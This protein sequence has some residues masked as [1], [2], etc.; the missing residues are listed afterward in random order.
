MSF[1]EYSHAPEKVPEKAP[2]TEGPRTLPGK[3]AKNQPLSTAEL[4]PHSPTP[5]RLRFKQAFSRQQEAEEEQAEGESKGKDQVSTKRPRV[6]QGAT[7]R[8]SSLLSCRAW[9]EPSLPSLPG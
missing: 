4:H 6:T 3:Q 2:C 9:A 7:E 1:P 8:A 5:T